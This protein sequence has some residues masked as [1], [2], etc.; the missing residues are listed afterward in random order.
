MGRRSPRHC[1][2]PDRAGGNV[3]DR[4][5]PRNLTPLLDELGR[6]HAPPGVYAVLGNHEY[7]RFP[8]PRGLLADLRVS[9]VTSFVNEG[10]VLCL[11]PLPG[12]RRRLSARRSQCG[13]ELAPKA[14]WLRDSAGLANPAV[15]PHMPS[16]VHLTPCSHTHGGQARLP[17]I[18]PFF[19]S[20][21]YGR[22]FA[23]GWVEAKARGYVSRGLGVVHLLVRLKCPPEHT[24]MTLLPDRVIAPES[25]L[26]PCST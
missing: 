24:A 7:R 23:S 15:L 10:L 13:G 8:S 6:L 4:Y 1:T 19:T 12:G 21:A 16:D 5:A 14:A 26:P 11:W 22:R 20:S 25:R 2:G 3:V 17:G 9:G 18:G